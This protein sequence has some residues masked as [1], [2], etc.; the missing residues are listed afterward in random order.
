MDF[1]EL[2]MGFKETG[3]PNAHFQIFVILQLE[4][5]QRPKKVTERAK[6]EMF[7]NVFILSIKWGGVYLFWASVTSW[8]KLY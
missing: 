6:A 8:T 7:T 3:F 5:E 4:T 1:K 2:Y